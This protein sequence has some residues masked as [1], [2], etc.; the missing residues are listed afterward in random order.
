M[1]PSLWILV[2]GLLAGILPLGAQTSPAVTPPAANQTP[3]ATSQTVPDWYLDKPIAD[4]RFDGLVTVQRSDIEGVTRPYLGKKFSES[5]FQDLQAALY[6]LDY[7]DGLIVPTAIKANDQ[8]SAVILLFKVTEKPVVD[9]I[10]FSGNQK[11]RTGELQSVLTVKKGDLVN[12]TKIRND[13]KALE[14]YYR[15]RGFLDAAIASS[16]VDSDPKKTKVVFKIT[17]G[18]QTAV[19]TIDFQGNEFASVSTLKGLMETK[20]QGLF[21]NG[22]FKEASFTKDMRAIETY[23]WNHGYI[24]ARIVDVQRNVTFD[25][26]S[27]RNVLGLVLTIKEGSPLIFGGFTF[28][29]NQIFTTD[30]LQA[31]VRQPVGKTISKE[32][33]EADYQRVVDLYLEDG[34]IF[35]NISRKEIRDGQTISYKVTIVER[36]RAHIENIVV[37][38]NTKTKDKVVLREMPVEVGDVFSKAKIVSGIKNL[39]N[40]Q[41]FSTV[42]PET[43]QGSADGLMDLVLNVEEGKTADISFG[44]SFSGTSGTFPLAAQIKWSDKNFLGNGQTLGVSSS[45]SPTIQSINTSFTENWFLDQRLTLGGSLGFSHSVNA[46]IDQDVIAPT[47]NNKEIPDPYTDGQYV[48]SA[49]KT[50]NGHNYNAGDLFPGIATSSD[51]SN[52]GLITRYQYDLNN[53]TVKKNAQ[54]EYDAW[55]FSAGVNTGYSWYTNLGRFSL[56]TGEKSSVQLVTYDSTIYRPDNIALR[57]N[58]DVWQLSNQW[59]TKAAWDTRDIVYNPTNGFLLSETVTFAGGFLGGYTDFTRFDTQ[60]E[61]YLKFFSW[62]LAETY[63]LD[64]VLKLRSGFSFLLPSVGGPQAIVAEPTDEIYVDG[65]LSGRGWGYQ[66]GGQASWTSGAEI[67]TP[68]P[69]AGQFLWIDTFIDHAVL[70]DINAAPQYSNPFTVPLSQMEFSW[71]TGLRVVTPQFPIAIYVVKPFQFDSSG[72]IVWIKGDGLFGSQADMKLVV[73]FGSQY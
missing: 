10:D 26:A 59:W 31:Q 21:D 4:I 43:P 23:Y 6:N 28:E 72:N 2:L 50:Y 15:D 30:V 63:S 70:I 22:L 19:K 60:A 17:E 68:V 46:L 37:K 65:M 69:F 40:L 55:Q 35:N 49:P 54:M 12:Q 73:S 44:L 14:S 41:Y 66:T 1:K 32:R 57:N 51:I 34:Y 58:L 33:L 5:L 11:L 39:Y 13:E 20:V 61:N 47:Y 9:D 24:D 52:Y 36:P 27:D 53:G 8:G 18:L 42:T 16:V 25:K 29:G 62:P 71:G 64:L 7:F 56:G 45:L 67:R 3:P 48:F 38:G